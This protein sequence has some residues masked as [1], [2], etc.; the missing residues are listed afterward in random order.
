MASCMKCGSE[1]SHDEIAIY[2]SLVNRGAKEYWCISCLASHKEVE[3]SD[4]VIKLNL[5][6]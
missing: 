6:I 1:L 4:I 3:I 2:K 5:C